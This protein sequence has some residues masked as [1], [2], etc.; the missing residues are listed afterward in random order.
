MLVYHTPTVSPTYT[1]GGDWLGGMNPTFKLTHSRVMTAALSAA[2]APLMLPAVVCFEGEAR[3]ATGVGAQG[4]GAG[5]HVPGLALWLWVKIKPP[6]YGC[7][8]KPMVPFWDRCTT[9]FRTYFIGD[10]DVHWGYDS[11]FDPWPYGPRWCPCFHLPN[12][13]PISG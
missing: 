7:G 8:S 11:D 10:W 9:H 4:A 6:G 1:S 13:Q 5:G 2:A 12:E 3:R